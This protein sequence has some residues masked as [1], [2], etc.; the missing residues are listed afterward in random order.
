MYEAIKKLEME[1]DYEGI[2]NLYSNE[3]IKVHQFGYI[4]EIK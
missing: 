4:L 3:E 1:N 2:K